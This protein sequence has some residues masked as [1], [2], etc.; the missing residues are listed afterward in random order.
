MV[1]MKEVGNH[2]IIL[3]IGC[4]NWVRGPLISVDGHLYDDVIAFPPV[5]C[6]NSEEDV[7]NHVYARLEE[8]SNHTNSE[9]LASRAILTTTNNMVDLLNSKIVK[10]LPADTFIVKSVDSLADQ[11][12]SALYPPEFLN[13]INLSNGSTT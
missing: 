9:W 1:R 10:C 5:L 12:L 6:V 11:N 2:S 3:L 13:S 4:C 8:P 7:I